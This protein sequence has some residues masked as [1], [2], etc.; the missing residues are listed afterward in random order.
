MVARK[1]K[2][3]HLGGLKKRNLATQKDLGVTHFTGILLKWGECEKKTGLEKTTQKPN[4]RYP[5]KSAVRIRHD[6]R[7]R[8]EAELKKKKES[9]EKRCGS[10]VGGN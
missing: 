6:A 8:T 2:K 1:G 3:K 5:K 7:S 10:L 4:G 9:W